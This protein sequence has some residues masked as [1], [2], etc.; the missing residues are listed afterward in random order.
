M[1]EARY[2]T[3]ALRGE[4]IAEFIGTFI[5]IMVG[6]GSVIV[7]VTL[8]AI[9]A[10]GVGM[11]WTLGVTLAIYSVGSI[12]GAHINP[13]VTITMAVFQGF[14]RHK[15]LPYIGAQIAGAFSG[16]AMLYIFWRGGI[17]EFE[18]EQG[19]TR[20]DEGS[21]LSGM[22]FT[23]YTP[24][25]D[26][27]GTDQEGWDQ[28]PLWTGF[29]AEI[30]ATAFL[31]MAV[32]YLTDAINSGRPLGNMAPIFI[33]L[34]VGVLVVTVG[35]LTQASLNPARDFGPRLFILLAGWDSIAIPGPRNEMWIT[36]LGPVIGGLLG[37]AIYMKLIRPFYPPIAE[38]GQVAGEAR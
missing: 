3:P 33:G 10:L 29:M 35:P 18:A 27:F 37:G 19:I 28:V 22:L 9:D 25:P 16:A 21:Q 4:M 26:A 5:L 17:R 36:I 8:G 38:P 20:G 34:T 11:M 32:L 31:L 12:S 30:V 1:S 14:E 24:N 13:A 7:A 23:T 15:V 2:P 6:C